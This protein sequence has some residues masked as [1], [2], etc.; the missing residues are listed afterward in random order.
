MLMTF[1]A[2][3]QMGM[4]SE[5]AKDKAFRKFDKFNSGKLEIH[6]FFSLCHSLDLH[7]NAKLAR[8]W[9]GH[10]N[11]VDGLTLDQVKSICASILAAQTPA[12]RSCTAGKVLTLSELQASEEF[13]PRGTL[14]PATLRE[15]LRS[16]DFPDVHC[17]HFD[18][19]VGEWL[20][21]A[22]KEEEEP[23]INVHDFISCVNLLVDVCQRHQEAL[24]REDP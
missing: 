23:V 2:C 20:V 5:Y 22:G 10:L 18:R 17:D 11:Q 16:L 4:T 9:L 8:E 24:E 19:Y 14:V 12:V 1:L 3:V 21:I 7:L 15:L 6:S 13:A